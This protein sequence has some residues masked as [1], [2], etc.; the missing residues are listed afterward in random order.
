LETTDKRGEEILR[1]PDASTA[2]DDP[3]SLVSDPKSFELAPGDDAVLGD[4]VG[5]SL[6][7]QLA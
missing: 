5:K 3:S 4:D 7:D 6:E 1:V 2:I